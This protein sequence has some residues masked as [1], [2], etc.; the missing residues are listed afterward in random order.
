MAQGTRK[1]KISNLRFQISN[2]FCSYTLLLAPYTFFNWKIMSFNIS[3]NNISDRSLQMSFHS[4][5]LN[6]KNGEIIRAVVGARLPEGGTLLSVNGRLLN[7]STDL[8]LPEGSKQFFQVSL[9]GSKI[10]LKLIEAPPLKP[11]VPVST[12]T[13]SAAK[14]TLTGVLSELKTTLDQAGLSRLTAN[15][16]QS[17]RQIMPQILYGNT[18]DHNGMWVKENIL[19]GGMLWENKVA[20]FLADEK[21]NSIKKLIKG[22]LKGILLSLQKGLLTE[23][24]DGSDAIATKVKQALNLIEGNQLLNLTTLEDGLGWLFVIPGLE[25]D[26]FNKAEIF[27]KKGDGKSGV[28]FS[29]LLE[30]TQLGQFEANVSIIE[31]RTSIRILTD[32]EEKAGFVN[33]NLPML[34]AGLKALGL[35]DVAISCAV[36]KATDIPGGLI[37][38]LAGRSR[39]INI[40]I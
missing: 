15:E 20:E 32:D 14:E 30:F 3:D 37:P 40:V 21:N 26:G 12:M 18:R 6:L 23:D 16:L 13:S 17:L 7:I 4:G 33:D 28:F 22:D 34:D 24:K 36:R 38:A 2:S 35:C 29:V 39:D 11:G 25:K 1:I 5:K 8:N 31:S 27:L 19:A 10:E 9:T